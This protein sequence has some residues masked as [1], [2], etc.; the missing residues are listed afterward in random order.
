MKDD[1]FYFFKLV[2]ALNDLK[3]ETIYKTL[4]IIFS[5]IEMMK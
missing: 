5:Y 3:K 1:Y 4:S 2:I